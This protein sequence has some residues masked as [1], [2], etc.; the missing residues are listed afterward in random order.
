MQN[1]A[2]IPTL[3]FISILILVSFG[4]TAQAPAPTPTSTP[5]PTKTAKPTKTPKPTATPRPTSTPDV[6]ATKHADELQAEVE[7]YFDKGYIATTDGVFKELDDFNA[8]WAQLQ[9]YRKWTYSYTV[10]DFFMSGHLKWSSA[11]RSADISGCGYVFGLQE[12]NEHY[13][14]FLDRS[15]VYFVHTEEYYSPMSPT[16]GTGRVK[17][18]NPADHPIEADFTVIVTD[19]HAYVLVNDEVVGEYMLSKSKKLEGQVGLALLSGTNKD[20][21]TRCDIT[22]LHVWH[23]KE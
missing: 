22:N 20:F 13:A 10:S 21:G 18:D 2:R 12:D 6:E 3:L 15:R 23:P 5:K 8:E 7:N 16:R 1:K 14:V 17:F 19:G 4:C 11:Y 9:W